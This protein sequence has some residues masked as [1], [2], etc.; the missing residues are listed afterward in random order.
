MDDFL[1][2]LGC[3]VFL[4]W[5][6]RYFEWGGAPRRTGDRGTSSLCSW[7]ACKSHHCCVPQMEGTRSRIQNKECLDSKCQLSCHVALQLPF[8]E[9]DSLK[10][11]TKF[12]FYHL[13]SGCS[14]QNLQFWLSPIMNLNQNLD[15]TK[16]LRRFSG[17]ISLW[18]TSLEWRYL[19]AMHICLM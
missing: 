7:C 11:H 9:G 19:R 1:F 16:Q 14:I 8:Q 2:V 3:N 4:G 17:L 5:K 6:L 12:A 15:I 13:A 18:M 10:C